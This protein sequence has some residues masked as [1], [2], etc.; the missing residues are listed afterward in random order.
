MVEEG[1]LVCGIPFPVTFKP[2]TLSEAK[3]E[4]ALLKEEKVGKNTGFHP[5]EWRVF[6]HLKS[7]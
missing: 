2:L 4:A 7:F 3:H 6:L 1:K 5:G